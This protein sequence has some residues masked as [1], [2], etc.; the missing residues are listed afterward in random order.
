MFRYLT[1]K[2]KGE[3][4]AKKDPYAD[5]TPELK[6]HAAACNNDVKMLEKLAK[7]GV[8]FNEPRPQ[9]GYYALD[10]CAWSGNVEA[11]NVLLQHGAD[12]SI[13]LQALISAGGQVDQELNSETALRWAVQFGH[14]DCALLLVQ[15][16]AWKLE[17][18]QELL[19]LRAKSRRMRKLLE[20]I[21]QVDPD[22]AADCVVPPC[23]KTCEIL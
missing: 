23:W 2:L 19:L 12:P 4:D 9:D 14:E 3:E 21:A 16:G 22:R 7:D 11:I 1:K 17:P 18:N 10:S 15:K 6:V 5:L 13:T 8:D 20:G